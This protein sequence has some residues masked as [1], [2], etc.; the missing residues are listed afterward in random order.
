MRKYEIMI[1]I[2]PD[3]DERQVP[4]LLE[5]HLKVIT[6]SNGT[7]DG[8]DVWGKR[9]MAYEINKKAEGTY[10]VLNV[11]AP[12]DAVKEMDR[13]MSIDEQIMRAKVMRTDKK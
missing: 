1:I 4:A 2:D 7:V 8:Q 9:R 13:L 12:A 3:V 5:K 11:T 10:A 6:A